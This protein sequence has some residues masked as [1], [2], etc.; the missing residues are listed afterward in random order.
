M[1]G[2]RHIWRERKEHFAGSLGY[3]SL[4]LSLITQSFHTQVSILAGAA[5]IIYGTVSGSGMSPSAF[6]DTC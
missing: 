3:F 5:P 4:L 6:V 1:G 2:D